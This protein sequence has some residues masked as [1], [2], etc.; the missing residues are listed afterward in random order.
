MRVG[1]FQTYNGQLG[2]CAAGRGG[3]PLREV[4]A[5]MAAPMR[6]GPQAPDGH[7]P[8]AAD[9]RPAPRSEQPNNFEYDDNEWDIGIGD[10][11][12]DL[13]LD[14]EKTDEG[15][16]AGTMACAAG[17]P[18]KAAAAK[19]ADHSA[20][21]DKGLKMK[22]KRTKPGTKTSEAKHEIVKSN[23]LNGAVDALAEEP[24]PGAPPARRASAAHRRDKA[25]EKHPATELNGA[26][27]P[28][29]E[30][31]GGP[32]PSPGPVVPPEAPRARP[33]APPA[34]PAT[35][36]SPAVPVA[37]VA[38]ISA[39]SAAASAT[40]SAAAAVAVEPP[41]AKKLKTDSKVRAPHYYS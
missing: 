38:A 27:A 18:A 20:T 2:L 22:I 21:L 11:I 6:D 3:A 10:L 34:A 33:V 41:P 26:A 1:L 31:P 5:R 36:P 25:R 13:D 12:I 4:A 16:A 39:A 32:V 8:R 24:V 29:P 19:L 14:I 23:E 30:P 9:G 28:V 17:G 35:A 40:A 15:T 7:R 37:V